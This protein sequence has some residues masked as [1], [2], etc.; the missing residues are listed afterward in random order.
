MRPVWNE[1]SAKIPRPS[2]RES[3]ATQP[4]SLTFNWFIGAVP[5]KAGGGPA[6]AVHR[7]RAGTGRVQ[8]RSWAGTLRLGGMLSRPCRNTFVSEA[9][10]GRRE[11]MAHVIA[12]GTVARRLNARATVSSDGG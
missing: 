7:A 10:M 8:E 4:S 11:S 3:A 1:W 9:A 12:D 6:L 5:S 2:S